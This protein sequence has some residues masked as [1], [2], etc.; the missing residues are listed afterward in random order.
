MLNRQ[1]IPH[2]DFSNH[3][4]TAVSGQEHEYSFVNRNPGPVDTETKQNGLFS[5]FVKKIQM[6]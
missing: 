6:D 3:Q 5:Q 2:Y 1:S 4:T